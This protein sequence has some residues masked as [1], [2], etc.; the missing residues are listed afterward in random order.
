MNANKKSIMM[1]KFMSPVIFYQ[2]DVVTVYKDIEGFS[3]EIGDLFTNDLL[4]A[5]AIMMR[6][7]NW[8]GLK[9]WDYE[10]DSHTINPINCIYWLSGGDV[11]WKNPELNKG[12]SE[13]LPD[14]LNKFENKVFEASKRRKLSDIRKYFKKHLNLDSFYEFALSKD[15]I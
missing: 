4:E 14:I 11:F 10:F 2:D 6:N 15:I 9:I 12:W 1:K 3:F 5:V 8:S 7:S 13:I